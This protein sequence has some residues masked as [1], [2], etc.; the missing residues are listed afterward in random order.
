MSPAFTGDVLV[1]LL[2]LV[3]T[4]A[5]AGGPLESVV[6]VLPQPLQVAAA[7][8][9]V[10]GVVGA[11]LIVGSPGFTRAIRDDV[12]DRP[13]LAFAVG[14]VVF[15]GVLVAASVPL[16]IATI[17]EHSA[18]ATVTTMV[19][20]PGLLL[21]VVLLVVG[22]PAG[23]IVLGDRLAGSLGVSAPSLA[24]ALALGVVVLGG[25]L[26]VPVLGALVAMGLATVAVGATVRRRF[27]VDGR[28]FDLEST[29][30]PTGER[31]GGPATDRRVGRV[32]DRHSSDEEGDVD[33]WVPDSEGKPRVRSADGTDEGDESSR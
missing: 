5:S 1:A 11:G 31:A 9:A 17:V 23:A 3:T 27:D 2:A 6:T 4:A 32:T 22:A 24:W 12:V 13:D 18:I 25:S 8:T 28:L 20:L 21:W 29:T 10:A 19:S 15:F 33:R 14:F 16:F 7:G 26:L 30:D